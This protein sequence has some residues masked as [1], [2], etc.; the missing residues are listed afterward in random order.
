MATL[1]EQELDK[2]VLARM[3]LQRWRV[4][5]CD[6]EFITHHHSIV[7]AALEAR[8]QA[9]NMDMLGEVDAAETAGD[10]D[11]ASDI[12]EEYGSSCYQAERT[13]PNMHRCAI[14]LTLYSFTEAS[15]ANYCR[16]LRQYLDMQPPEPK[17]GRIENYKGWLRGINIE[18]V[19]SKPSWEEIDAFR[20]LRN[21]IVHAY[22]DIGNNVHLEAHIESSPHISFSESGLGDICDGFEL[23]ATFVEYATRSIASFFEKLTDDLRPLFPS[24]EEAIIAAMNEHFHAERQ[25]RMAKRASKGGAL[26]IED[27]FRDIL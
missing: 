16:L 14:L 7:E 26:T 27:A 13:Y 6:L 5:L 19:A 3:I 11:L 18:F 1:S 24:S 2:L 8:A 12:S 10:V 21:S 20:M 23:E 22:G 17:R 9:V 25:E 15:L 4:I